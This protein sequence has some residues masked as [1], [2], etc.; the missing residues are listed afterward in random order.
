MENNEKSSPFQAI[1]TWGLIAGIASIVYTFIL[2]FAGLMQNKPIQFAGIVISIVCLYLGIKSIRD[3]NYNGYISF[4]KSLGTGVLIGLIS[5]IVSTIFMVILYTVIDSGLIDVAL[6][7]STNQ[8]VAKGMS[9]SQ[10]EQA[11]GMT[12]KFFIPFL[13]IGGLIMG[14]LLGF[15][16]SLVL[17]I[18][19]KKEENP[20]TNATEQKA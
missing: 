4:G 13:A 17:S 16:I 3:Q 5:T 14:T 9:E 12:R 11:M 19:L 20:F 7:E 1:L 10:I 8:M 18:F 15:I 2:Y 6:Q